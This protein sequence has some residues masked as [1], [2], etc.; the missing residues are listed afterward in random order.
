MKEERS[1][2]REPTPEQLRFREIDEALRSKLKGSLDVLVNDISRQ[3]EQESTAKGASVG[4]L[5]PPPT[6]Y[7]RAIALQHLFCRLCSADPD[8]FAGGS[9]D[10]GDPAIKNLKNI[11]ATWTS[12]SGAGPKQPQQDM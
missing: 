10:I 9:S 11:A 8:S 4:D 12:Q 2:H 3:F 5:K 6:N 7:F 1:T